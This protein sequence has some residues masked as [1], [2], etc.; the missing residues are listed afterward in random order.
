MQYNILF[1]VNE[2]FLED[3]WGTGISPPLGKGARLRQMIFYVRWGETYDKL[4]KYVTV[5]LQNENGI[6]GTS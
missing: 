3:T 1:N 6:V 4:C 2:K 5:L